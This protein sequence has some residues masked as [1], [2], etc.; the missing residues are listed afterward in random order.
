MMIR[1]NGIAEMNL[2]NHLERNQNQTHFYRPDANK[3]EVK[4]DFGLIL[5]VEIKKLKFDVL[6]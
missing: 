2:Y 3:Q 6:I 4:K 1:V 5:D